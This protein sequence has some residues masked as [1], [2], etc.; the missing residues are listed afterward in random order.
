MVPLRSDAGKGARSLWYRARMALDGASLDS[1]GDPATS[2]GSRPGWCTRANALTAL[3]LALTPLLALA[4]ARDRAGFA[5]ALLALAIATDFADGVVARRYGEASP[6]GGLLDHAVDATLCV[7][8]VGALAVRGAA[9][10]ALPPLIGVAFLQYVVD[11]RSHRGRP[12]RASRLGRWN[13][14]AYYVLVATPPVRDVL[15]LGWP[16]HRLVWWLGAAL[17]AS[18]LLSMLDRAMARRAG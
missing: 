1:L 12:L 2:P 16:S 17:V 10:W 18:T 7:L 5:V 11:S 13:G 14:I 4:I 8:G 3:R 15:G 6:L 9:P